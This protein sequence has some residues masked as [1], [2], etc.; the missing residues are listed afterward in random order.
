MSSNKYKVLFVAGNWDENGGRTSKYMSKFINAVENYVG[1]SNLYSF[2]GGKYDQLHDIM[3]L[4]KEVEVVF[5]FPNIPG[6]LPRL[7][8][9]K[10][11]NREVVVLN[12]K[13]NDR[14]RYK[15]NE[16]ISIAISQKSD[17]TCEVRKDETGHYELRVVD[18]L[19][20][21]WAN[22]DTN[23]SKS[24]AKMFSRVSVLHSTTKSSSIKADKPSKIPKFDKELKVFNKAIKE[25]HNLND[26]REDV[27][28]FIGT[29]AIRD[30][31]DKDLIHFNKRSATIKG[32]DNTDL[33]QTK[34]VNEKTT[35]YS[36]YS[37]PSIN[38]PVYLRLLEQLPNINYAFHSHYYI[39]KAS[40]TERAVVDGGLEEVSEVI[41]VLS[42]ESDLRGKNY[43]V[44]LIG[45]GCLVL[46]NDINDLEDVDF[47]RRGIP[48]V[49]GTDYDYVMVD[50]GVNHFVSTLKGRV[51]ESGDLIEV[52]FHDDSVGTHEVKVK[53]YKEGD[54]KYHEA[55][56]E[57]VIKGAVIEFPLSGVRARRI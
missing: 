9:V 4:I 8:K 27:N 31:E 16:L 30:N 37:K 57:M 10:D 1:E 32:I 33:V 54:V 3:K 22:F 44:N 29:L 11:I 17:L 35:Y 55:Y 38:A 40:F 41:R 50:D 15:L 13:R 20:T 48:E 23:L 7:P 6:E 18:T 21:V 14:H 45:H 39:D 34:L 19:G 25:N 53:S 49:I 42:R 43:Q 5:W 12:Y 36:K 47:V 28:R 52:M 51:L 26:A 2:N 46:L 24:V 56:I